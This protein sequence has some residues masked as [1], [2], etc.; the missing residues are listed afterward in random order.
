MRTLLLS[1]TMTLVT[2]T[3]F[4]QTPQSNFSFADSSAVW[5]QCHTIFLEGPQGT[6]GV[7]QTDTYRAN[8][9]SFFNN[10]SYQKITSG[11]VSAS[12]FVRQDSTR[13]IFLY[14]LELQSD[15]MIY[16]FGL[17]Q[18]DTLRLYK[19][20]SFFQGADTLKL[21]VDSTDSV[22]Y[23]VSRKRMFMRCITGTYCSW[24]TNDIIIEGI[25]SLNSHFLSPYIYEFLSIPGEAFRLLNFE[26]NG[27]TYSFSDSCGTVDI[28]EISSN[29]IKIYPNPFFN[30]LTF[31]HADNAQTTISLYNFLGQRVLQQ[32]FTK[33]TTINTEQLSEGIYFYELWSNKGTLKTGKL[34]KQ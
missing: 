4:S 17:N 24:F 13:K 18:G 21:V 26:E 25:G 33:S 15:R 23:G 16:D 8:Q 32:T 11:F 27:S 5:T 6:W 29:K 9:D 10:L 28:S 19:P 3:S 7:Q 31:S 1:I 20:A 22:V 34:V 14:D 12:A 2:V 30:Q